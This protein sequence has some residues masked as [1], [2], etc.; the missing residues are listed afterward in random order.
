MTRMDELW[1]AVGGPGTP[2]AADSR[3]VR[4]RVNAALDADRN[5]RRIYMRKKLR[6]GMAT[7][8]AVI[9]VTGSALAVTNNWDMIQVFFKGDT[10]PAQEYVDSTARSVSDGNYTLT[11]ESSM[12]DINN[13]IYLIVTLTASKEETREFLFSDAFDWAVKA[14]SIR[15]VEQAES[16]AYSYGYSDRIGEMEAPDENS[17]R[18][19]LAVQFDQSESVSALLVGSKYMDRES[20]VEVPVTPAPSVTVELGA[21][22]VGIPHSDT[23]TPGTLTVERVTLSPFTCQIECADVPLTDGYQTLPRIF[24]RMADG[25]IRTQ[26]QMMEL[27]GTDDGGDSYEGGGGLT[28][29]RR[30]YIY[31]FDE[32]QDL[33]S[34]SSILAFDTEY[35]LDG[36]AST[37]LEHDPAL[38]LFTLPGMEP[39]A[40]KYGYSLSAQALTEGLG[41]ACRWDPAAGTMTCVF[42]GV[43]VVLRSGDITAMVDG[44][45][46]TMIAAPA[47]QDGVL[48]VSPFFLEDAWGIDCN[49]HNV[50]IKEVQGDW[51]IIP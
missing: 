37:R 22:G 51:Y 7:V 17:R 31:E 35:P 21:S 36:S 28:Y 27:T 46:V 11:V 33:A 14:I 24:F 2:P 19:H 10:A 5:E 9:A 18:F 3:A 30:Y 25:S 23:S 26:S 41:G 12:S 34:I 39:L 50:S 49:L 13:R 38:D 6:I 15:S 48:A 47:M 42:R 1:K 4:A 16:P 45:P 20:E 43:T 8:A 32:I 40:E 29:G 44:Q